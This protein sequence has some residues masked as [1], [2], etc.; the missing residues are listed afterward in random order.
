MLAGKVSMQRGLGIFLK[1]LNGPEQCY[2]T[3]AAH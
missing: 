2:A 3:Q 1:F